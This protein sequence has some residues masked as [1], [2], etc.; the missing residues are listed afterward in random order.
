MLC[1]GALI[2]P[3][4]LHLEGSAGG[5]Q[6]LDRGSRNYTCPPDLLQKSLQLL[7]ALVPLCQSLFFVTSE[8]E[9]EL[10]V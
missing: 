7:L 6:I 9:V 3:A 10:G 8:M 1:S 4:S 2:S 5:G